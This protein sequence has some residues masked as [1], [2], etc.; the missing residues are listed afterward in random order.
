MRTNQQRPTLVLASITLLVVSALPAYAGQALIN[1]DLRNKKA[2]QAWEPQTHV[3][4]CN[5]TQFNPKNILKNIKRGT[6][7]L[8]IS[9]LPSGDRQF[10][11]G[12]LKYVGRKNTPNLKEQT[13]FL[14]G[15]FSA[16]IKTSHF[17]GTVSS[18]FL[19][20]SSPWQEID[21]EFLGNNPRKIQFNIYFNKG[22]DG[23]PNNDYTQNSPIQ[24]DLPFD[25]S[26]AFHEYTI[27]WAPNLIRWYVDGKVFREI[28]DPN[29]VPY[30]GMTLRMN[31]WGV[32]DAAS[33]W[34]GAHFDTERLKQGETPTVEYQWIRVWGRN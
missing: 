16:S 14:Y 29:Q 30:L 33:D 12:E 5:E 17:P 31:H 3:F 4:H 7:G 24:M 1:S 8:M 23:E 6:V 2:F 26:E 19:Y 32:C 9:S 34:A 18:L 27:E 10:S 21:I 11:G 28:T 22:K 25:S 20:R 15:R 13:N